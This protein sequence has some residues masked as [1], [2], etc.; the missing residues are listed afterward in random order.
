MVPDD[1]RRQIEAADQAAGIR[2]RATAA[3]HQ[4]ALLLHGQSPSADTAGE[5]E[6]TSAAADAAQQAYTRDGRHVT[7]RHAAAMLR[8]AAA[9]TAQRE[10]SA[11]KPAPAADSTRMQ[12]NRAALAANEAYKAGDLD[13]ARVLTDHAAALDPSRAGLWQQHRND[14]AARRLILSARAAHAEGD[15]ERAGKLLQDARQL[16]PRL[17]TLWDSSLPAQP[18]AR[19]TR[20]ISRHDTPPPG[21]GGTARNRSALP[22]ARS[23]QRQP[24]ATSQPG[25]ETPQPAWPSAPA[26]REPG[27]PSPAAAQP[28]SPPSSRQPPATAA[29]PREP[30]GPACADVKDPDPD[31]AEDPARWPSPNPRSQPR[32]A[33]SRQDGHG[34]AANQAVPPQRGSRTAAPDP[35]PAADWRDQILR[36]ARQP[37]SFAPSWPHHPSLARDPHTD[38]P[39]AGIEPG[40]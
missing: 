8:W 18:A 28:G 9:I 29:A 13:Q 30:E 1:I 11:G 10:Q 23:Q 20:E 15:H 39:D 33:P 21:A 24:A 5:V 35:A 14:I 3:A 17:R 12:A 6:R 38:T 4:Q 32:A 25:Q 16:D 7:G 37:W 36:D 19:I 26:R 27:R 34:T 40:R 22:P 2:R 31:A